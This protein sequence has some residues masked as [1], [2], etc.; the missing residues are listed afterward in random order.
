M[1]I[2]LLFFCLLMPFLAMAEHLEF[3]GI[4]ID[5]TFSAFNDNLN[6]QGYNTDW[7]ITERMGK[8]EW[9]YYNGRYFNND[10]HLLVSYD[11]STKVVYSV[12]V[13]ITKP[14][15]P[16]ARKLVTDLKN[17]LENKYGWKF[18]E[19][20]HDY[21]PY[22]RALVEED[23][24]FG[25]DIGSVSIGYD[26]DEDFDDYDVTVFFYDYQNADKN[27]MNMGR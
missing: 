5:G 13:S 4:P 27:R 26:Y 10:C 9:A 20:D 2:R 12:M 24:I 7:D 11:P 14:T 8:G 3:R 19:E 6:R 22:Y 1:K 21:H 17:A 16:A 15:Q 23:S 25:D 18:K